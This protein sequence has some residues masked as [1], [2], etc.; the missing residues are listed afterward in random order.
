MCTHNTAAQRR[1]HAL[2]WRCSVLSNSVELCRL[3]QSHLVHGYEPFVGSRLFCS[4]CALLEQG[5]PSTAT[6]VSNGAAGFPCFPSLSTGRALTHLCLDSNPL[7]FAS[8]WV[9]KHSWCGL[10]VGFAS[11]SSLCE[12]VVAS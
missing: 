6:S 4:C 1:M 2:Q 8:M 11:N 10:F 12:P 3:A 9:S 5:C 7:Q